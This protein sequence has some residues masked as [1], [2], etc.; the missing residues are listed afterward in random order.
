M[1]RLE[2]SGGFLWAFW[3]PGVG[4]DLVLLTMYNLIE[5]RWE[6]QR[7]GENQP[8]ILIPALDNGD[9][10]IRSFRIRTVELFPLPPKTPA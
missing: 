9:Q 7:E 5:R 1:S 4:F 8:L 10:Q 3:G 2:R 6:E